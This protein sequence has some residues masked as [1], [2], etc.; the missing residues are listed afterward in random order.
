[1]ADFLSVFFLSVAMFIVSFLFGY[2]PL[3]FSFNS[4]KLKLMSI[5]GAGLLVGTALIVIIPEGIHALYSVESHGHDSISDKKVDHSLQSALSDS[6]AKEGICI[7]LPDHLH[8]HSGNKAA[9][10]LENPDTFCL[11]RSALNTNGI[12]LALALGFVFMLV[13]DRLTGD[14]HTHGTGHAHGRASSLA[15]LEEE[16]K[17]L[18]STS[19][20][21]S[22][23]SDPLSISSTSKG[24]SKLK[25]SSRHFAKDSV[26]QARG[27]VNT[28]SFSAT[29]GLMVHAAVDGFALGAASTNNSGQ[30][31]FIVFM[32]L[33]M[34]KA[35]AA[36]ALG[37]FLLDQGRPR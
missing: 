13:V 3:A 19:I 36:F 20:S 8:E 26:K 30:V 16:E 2:L 9:S 1:M 31:E 7:A 11:N 29:I 12:G 25:D 35:P 14:L 28:R 6:G 5:M 24:K 33:M 18:L 37:S 15:L 27:T 34:H 17:G 32:A 4:E 21:A 22:S 10:H 23:D